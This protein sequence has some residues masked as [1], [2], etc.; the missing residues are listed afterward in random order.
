MTYYVGDMVT[1]NSSPNEN[2]HH[3]PGYI[4]EMK[5]Y[6]V[7]VYKIWLAHEEYPWYKLEDDPHDFWWDESWLIKHNLY[8][9]GSLNN[10]GN[11]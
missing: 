4:E 2:P 7:V 11:I 3:S 8:T 5:H 6:G 1:I 9:N 10:G